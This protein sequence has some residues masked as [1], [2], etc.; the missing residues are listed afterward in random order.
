MPV[1]EMIRLTGGYWGQ[2][3]ASRYGGMAQRWLVVYSQAA[4]ERELASLERRQA[5]AGDAPMERPR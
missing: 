4:Y 5:R 1:T 3:V 2:E